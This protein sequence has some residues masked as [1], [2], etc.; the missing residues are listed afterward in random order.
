MTTSHRWMWLSC[1]F[2]I[3]EISLSKLVSKVLR[4]RRAVCIVAMAE[5]QVLP[6]LGQDA[7]GDGRCDGRQGEARKSDRDDFRSIKLVE[8]TANERKIHDQRCKK[9][10]FCRPC[11]GF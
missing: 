10:S 4:S 8:N 6:P 9:E 11:A 3:Q 5:R 2:D 1:V 7:A